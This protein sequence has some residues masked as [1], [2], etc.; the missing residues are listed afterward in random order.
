MLPF[1]PLSSQIY[2]APT[3]I[4]GTAPTIYTITDIVSTANRGTFPPHTTDKLI[5]PDVAQYVSFSPSQSI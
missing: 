4:D 3:L 1:I 5:H 2:L